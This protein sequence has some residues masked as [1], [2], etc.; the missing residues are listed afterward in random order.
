[1]ITLDTSA[2]IAIADEGDPDHSAVSSALLADRGPWIVSA[3][4]LGEVGYMLESISADA[5]DA[6][7]QDLETGAYTLDCG[8]EDWNRIRELVRRYA[9]L[10]LGLAD[11]SVIACAERNAGGVLTLDR[12]DFQ[13][14][15]RE[16]RITVIPEN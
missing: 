9:D 7:L 10:P 5:V 13:V 2:I 11:A 16:G 8:E 6:F 4:I 3:G 1:V 14:I 12:R 15:A